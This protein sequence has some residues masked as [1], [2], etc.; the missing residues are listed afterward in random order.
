MV[1]GNWASWQDLIALQIQGIYITELSPPF[2]ALPSS[3]VLSIEQNMILIWPYIC[4]I[5]YDHDQKYEIFF[6]ILTLNKIR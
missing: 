4:L 6:N 3:L 5:H 1:Q 2:L